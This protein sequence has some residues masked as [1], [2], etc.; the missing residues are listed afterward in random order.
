MTRALLCLLAVACAPDLEKIGSGKARLPDASRTVPLPEGEVLEVVPGQAPAVTARG[1][2]RIVA[3]RDA[4]WSEVAAAMDAVHAAGGE[5][6]LAM[7]YRTHVRALP[8]F[9]P[10]VDDPAIRIIA[11][12]TRACI[13]LPEADQ[14]HCVSRGDKKHIDRAGLRE[15]LRSIVKATGITRVRVSVWPTTSYADAIRAIDGART[16]CFEQQIDVA[17]ETPQ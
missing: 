4:T 11:E 9:A 17:L 5:P 12:E 14:G 16:C 8:P 1:P 10:R 7:R 13:W 2:V 6:W 3:D 15:T